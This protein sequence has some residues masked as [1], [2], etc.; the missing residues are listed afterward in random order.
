MP[1]ARKRP[2]FFAIGRP[3]D[4]NERI[5]ANFTRQYFLM[6]PVLITLS[7]LLG[8]L[9]AGTAIQ[10]LNS[11][12]LAAENITGSNLAMQIPLRGAGDELDHLIK[13]FNRMTG[14]LGES[15][16][17]IRRFSTDVSHELRTP[18]TAV[19]GQL[20]VAL[21]TA[22]KPEQFREAMVN[23]LED[24]EK[25]SSI[26]RALLLLSQAESG[27]VVLQKELIDIGL[28]ASDVVDQFQIPALE[29]QIT[30]KAQVESGLTVPGDPIQIERLISNLVSNALKYTPDGGCVTVR[31][32][33]GELG[34]T[35]LEIEDT[36]YGIA[37][38][39]LPHI[40]ERF[41]RVRTPLTNREEG[42]GLGLSFVSWIV[43]AHNGK[44]DV[45]SQL[46]KGTTFTILLPS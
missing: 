24:V 23:A 13:S 35:K 14:R 10:P 32:G 25:L 46:G 18:L 15:F 38:E 43:S 22:E 21:F 45:K 36:G 29:K 16:E 42:L 12:A 20:E 17:N 37:P 31:A 39:N 5:L 44:L 7:S 2:Y 19:R 4:Q 9:V 8:W 41:Y 1:D 33:R 28:I 27:Q 11:V 26:V 40:F 3:I 34:W 30:V 6:V